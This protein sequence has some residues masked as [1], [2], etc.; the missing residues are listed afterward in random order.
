MNYEFQYHIIHFPESEP[1]DHIRRIDYYDYGYE[2][3]YITST[4]D[5]KIIGHGGRLFFTEM[6][7]DL[8]SDAWLYFCDGKYEYDLA[9]A[10][11]R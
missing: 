11:E 2:L 6:D 8:I 7:Q 4:G 5:K 3:L 1:D 9:I 10:R